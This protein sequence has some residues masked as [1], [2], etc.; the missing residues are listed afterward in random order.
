[1]PTLSEF[2]AWLSG[3]TDLPGTGR[4]IRA[5]RRAELLTVLL[6]GATRPRVDFLAVLAER[7]H[8]LA[9]DAWAQRVTDSNRRRFLTVLQ[10]RAQEI[11]K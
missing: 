8:R 2:R 3:D 11:R 4:G 7:Q 6:R 9:L 5:V 1:M 10:Q